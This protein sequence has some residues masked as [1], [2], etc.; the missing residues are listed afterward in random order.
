MSNSVV[1]WVRALPTNQLVIGSNPAG[2][3]IKFYL[4]K[5]IFKTYLWSNLKIL[6]IDWC[7]IPPESFASPKQYLRH[8]IKITVDFIYRVFTFYLYY[9]YLLKPKII[10]FLFFNNIPTGIKTLQLWFEVL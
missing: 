9:K 7:P 5:K 3:C 6:N 2:S 10:P 1:Q 4:S 8:V